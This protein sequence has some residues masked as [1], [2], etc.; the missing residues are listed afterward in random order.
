M[1]TTQVIPPG[2]ST[3][4]RIEGAWENLNRT[5]RWWATVLAVFAGWACW[6]VGQAMSANE[7]G[8]VTA[9]AAT[10]ASAVTA[11]AAVAA[12]AAVTAVAMCAGCAA[13]VDAST[14]RIPNRLLAV[15]ATAVAAAVLAGVAGELIAP[16]VDPHGAAQVATPTAAQV[17]TPAAARF[18][19]QITSPA[20]GVL[21]GMLG[22]AVPMLVVRLQRGAGVGGLGMGDV[23]LAAVLGAAGGLVDARVGLATVFLAALAASTFAALTHRRRMALGPWLFMAWLVTL[24]VAVEVA[25]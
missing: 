14:Q 15:A 8:A 20:T 11:V 23:K 18:A 5:Q 2:A 21:L 12:V 17:A 24:V 3:L 22:A 19:G 25:S 6:E 13:L 16:H 4:G 10:A 9:T 1:G 7:F